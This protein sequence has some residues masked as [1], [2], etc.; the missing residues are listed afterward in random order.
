[1]TSQRRLVA[2]ILLANVCR[3]RSGMRPA[4]RMGPFQVVGFRSRSTTRW[5]TGVILDVYD[6]V[7]TEE[8]TPM[9]LDESAVAD[10]TDALGVGE[11][12]DQV[13]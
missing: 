10:L 11:G 4:H 2:D 12:T 6:Q 5:A 13:R 8:N 1:M 9:A 3:P 7:H